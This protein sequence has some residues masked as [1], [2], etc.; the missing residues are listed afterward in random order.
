M[1]IHRSLLYLAAFLTAAPALPLPGAELELLD[2]HARAFDYGYGRWS[3]L[4]EIEKKGNR[5]IVLKGPAD[6]GAGIV[7]HTPKDLSSVSYLLVEL[8]CRSDSARSPV[9]LKLLSSDE[10][11]SGWTLPVDHLPVGQPLLFALPVDHPDETGPGGPAHI[12][13]ITGLQIHGNW[14][15][16]CTVHIRV[17]RVHASTTKP[18]KHLL[19][20]QARTIAASGTA[21]A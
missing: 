1:K 9:K 14:Q 2:G 7:F 17:S 3:T 6:G 10:K 20:E 4:A 12:G 11:Q 18:D 21:F 5:G 19:P 15:A 16:D 13:Q 8:Q